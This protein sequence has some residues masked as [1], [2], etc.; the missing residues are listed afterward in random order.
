MSHSWGGDEAV[1]YFST[2]EIFIPAGRKIRVGF[3]NLM[4]Y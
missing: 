4:I 1:D 2:R 3:C